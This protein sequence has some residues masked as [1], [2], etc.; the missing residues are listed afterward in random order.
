LYTFGI[1]K[2]L[3]ARFYIVTG[4]MESR[5]RLGPTITAGG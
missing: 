1:F 2:N 3:S 5:S 4:V